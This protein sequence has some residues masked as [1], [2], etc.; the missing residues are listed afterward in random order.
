MNIKPLA[1]AVSLFSA[2]NI[3]ANTSYSITDFGAIPNDNIDDSAAFNHALSQLPDHG[4]L[5]IPS[6][7]Y[8][9][10]STLYLTDKSHVSLFGSYGAILKKCPEFKGEY[11]FF[12][13]NTDDLKISNLHFMGLFNGGE[14]ANWGKQGMYL[15]STTNSV[16]ANNRFEHF[17][18]AALRVTTRPIRDAIQSKDALILNN[19]FS[20]CAQVTTTQAQATEGFSVPSTHNIIFA[21][22]LF[23]NC[24]LKLSARKETKTAV[25]LNN[26]FKNINSTALEVSYYGNVTISHNEFENNSGFAINLYPNNRAPSPV[27]WGDITITD[28]LFHHSDLGLR[29]QSISAS[30]KVSDAVRNLTITKNIFRSMSCNG[31]DNDKYKKVIRTYSQHPSL[32]FDN[33]IISEN[34]FDANQGCGFLS[35]DPKDTNVVVKDNISVS[36]YEEKQDPSS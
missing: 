19:H 26:H 23:D 29:L 27:R 9:I 7:E 10:C 3:M 4:N 15:A 18:D 16:I 13:K 25:V 5:A 1:L 6:G 30:E 34:K 21:S 35:V 28:N 32:S 36:V 2:P 24:T 14:T 22:N 12:I 11:L 33:V 31:T 20:N 17:G 8:T